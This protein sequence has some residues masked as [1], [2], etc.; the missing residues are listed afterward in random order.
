MSVFLR[1][2][3]ARKCEVTTSFE[4]Q[5]Q[6]PHKE[7]LRTVPFTIPFIR[8]PSSKHCAKEWVARAEWGLMTVMGL[9]AQISLQLT[10]SIRVSL[11]IQWASWAWNGIRRSVRFSLHMRPT[12]LAKIWRLIGWTAP[13][14]PGPPWLDHIDDLDHQDSRQMTNYNKRQTTN[15]QKRQTK[16]ND[17]QQTTTNNKQ[18]QTTPNDKQQQQQMA[19]KQK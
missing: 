14:T 7:D 10:H 6:K 2:P 13:W 9:E 4:Q 5:N 16:S 12:V 11:C 1:L 15:N 3:F 17:K 19:N 8:S 18:R